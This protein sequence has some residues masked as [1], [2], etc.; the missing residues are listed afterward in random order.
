MWFRAGERKGKHGG[1]GKRGGGGR[2]VER[3]HFDKGQ[4]G[5]VVA[6]AEHSSFKKVLCSSPEVAREQK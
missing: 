3:I 5:R 1:K 6:C 2:G 4:F